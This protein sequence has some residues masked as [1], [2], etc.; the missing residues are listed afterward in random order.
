MDIKEQILTALGIDKK[1]SLEW[2]AKTEDGTILVSTAEELEEGVDISVLTEDG[3]SIPLP[4]GTYILESGISFRVEVEGVVDH[5]MESESEE[6]EVIE[7]EM[8]EEEDEKK[9]YADVADWE[10]MERR[11]QQ[12]EDAIADLK[13]DKVEAKQ[14]DKDCPNGYDD[15]GNCIE[16][17]EMSAP[18]KNPKSIKTTEV[19]EFSLQ[20]LVEENKKLKE[21]LA[22]LPSANPLTTNKFSSEKVKVALN[23][24]QYNKLTS[25]EKFIYDLNN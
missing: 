14:D 13:E 3:T 10:G 17:E 6:K 16:E 20:T 15:D 9:G 19:K 23:K 7:E 8:A 18:T 25:K 5:L 24:T 2:Q 12:L 1:I 22:A 11:I 4:I 21:Q